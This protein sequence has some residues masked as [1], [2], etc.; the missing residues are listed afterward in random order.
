[1]EEQLRSGSAAPQ[2]QPPI[3]LRCPITCQLLTDPVI[4][5]ESAQT[6]ERA[7]IQEWLDRGNR[8]DPVTGKDAY[9]VG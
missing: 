3:D 5:V 4:L 9:V 6:Y 8:K 1:M 2:A 7:A